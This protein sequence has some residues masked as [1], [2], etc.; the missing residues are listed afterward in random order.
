MQKPHFSWPNMACLGPPLLIPKS[1]TKGLCGCC[2]SRAHFLNTSQLRRDSRN[3]PQEPF[4]ARLAAF[5]PII[6]NRRPA[7]GHHP[8]G[9]TLSKALRGNLPFREAS[10]GLSSRVLRLALQNRTIAIAS[11]FRIDGPKSPEIPQ[12]EGVLG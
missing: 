12:K 7:E 8:R 3:C 6:G 9:T 1:S 2:L 4:L 10:A 5:G 11:D